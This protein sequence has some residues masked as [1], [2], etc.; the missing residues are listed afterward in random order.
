[1][2]ELSDER[3][4]ELIKADNHLAFTV[5]VDRYWEKLYKHLFYRIKKEEE[6]KDSVQE[7]FISLWNN[8]YK[9]SCDAAGSLSSY[10]FKSARYCAIDYFSK[11]ETTIP[12]EQVLDLALEIPA[13]QPADANVLLNELENIISRE[14][15]SLPD[16]LQ[17]PYKMSREEHL[18]IKEI[19]FHLSISE[20]TVKNNI[21][22]VLN[23]LRLKIRQYHSDTTICLILVLAA[24]AH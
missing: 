1:M 4:L 22:M 15:S 9:L 10:L 23:K 20:Q 5:L 17:Q 18:S 3:I 7:I 11:P 14:I 6:S 2:K 24:L 12:Y 21:T 13:G 16:Q 19:A 8:R